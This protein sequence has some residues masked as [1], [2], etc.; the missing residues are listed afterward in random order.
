MRRIPED[1]STTGS[2]AVAGK[3]K[4]RARNCKKREKEFGAGE[5]LPLPLV[6]RGHGEVGKLQNSSRNG[7]RQL[8]AKG[9]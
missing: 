3:N 4:F 5:S 2:R 8:W 1:L 6:G 9:G 7:Q